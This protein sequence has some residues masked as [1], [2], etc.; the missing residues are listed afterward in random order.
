MIWESWFSSFTVGPRFKASGLVTSAFSQRAILLAQHQR[1]SELL[2]VL[3]FFFKLPFSTLI[4]MTGAGEMGPPSFSN[5]CRRRQAIQNGQWYPVYL[6]PVVMT[7]VLSQNLRKRASHRWRAVTPSA[8]VPTQSCY[9]LGT[10]FDVSEH[11]ARGRSST[12]CPHPPLRSSSQKYSE[13]GPLMRNQSPDVT[14]GSR[15]SMDLRRRNSCLQ[16]RVF[17][18]T[19][20]SSELVDI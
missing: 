19:C 17:V 4:Q 9:S 1:L 7:L 11:H 15:D 14:I 8:F 13:Q 10:E 2:C 18:Y 16:T 20:G 5:K 12:H 6:T 3:G